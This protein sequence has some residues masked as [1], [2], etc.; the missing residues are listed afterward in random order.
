MRVKR[1]IPILLIFLLT[2]LF[3]ATLNIKVSTMQGVNYRAALIKIPLY[4]KILD[5]F[6]R[7]YN[8]K[9]LVMRIT[10][11]ARTDEEKVLKI[12]AWTQSHIKPQPQELP[13]VDDHVWHIIV[14]GYGAG[15]Q[16]SDVFATLCNYA[17]ARAAYGWCY[18]QPETKPIV[19]VFVFINGQWRVFD[20]LRG[21]FFCLKSTDSLAGIEDVRSGNWRVVNVNTSG[22][23]DFEY[24]PYFRNINFS[25]EKFRRSALQKPFSRFWFMLMRKLGGVNADS[26]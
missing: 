20:L 5:F 12:F 26:F 4:L 23:T 7:H 3:V 2:I 14:R 6:D 9:A 15:E 8:Y 13:V 18:L 16:S 17:G 10:E 1:T 24:T 21:N 25:G 19:L 22:N 11:G